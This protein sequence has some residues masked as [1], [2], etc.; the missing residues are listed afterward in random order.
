MAV[1]SLGAASPVDA[2]PAIGAYAP[3]SVA[4][5][6][7]QHTMALTASAAPAPGL[8]T[9]TVWYQYFVYDYTT[10]TYLDALNP[11]NWGTIGAYSTVDNGFGATVI[12][13]GTT[14][15]PTSV[16]SVPAGH[17]FAVRTDYWW[18]IDGA[19]YGATGVWSTSFAETGYAWEPGNGLS[20]TDACFA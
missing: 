2:A 16:Y 5:D 6:Y 20:R 17:S 14:D 9:Q 18:F 11:T 1:F 3:A 4:C 8:A 19:W 13:L 15:A 10:A 12:N 7:R